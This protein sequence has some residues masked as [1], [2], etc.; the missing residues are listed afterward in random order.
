M[1]GLDG[2][3]ALVTGA[4]AGVGEAVARRLAEEGVRVVLADR[5]GDA[6]QAVA[7]T[8]PHDAVGVACDVASPDDVTA[9]VEAAA[10]LTGTI[11]I[12]V[13]IAGNSRPAMLKNLDEETFASVVDVHLG[14]TYRTVRT[15]LQYLPDDGTGRI[16]TTT[17]A[18]GQSG[19]IG[20]ANYAAAKAGI[21]GF[22][23]SCA[24][25]LARKSITANA[26]APLAATAMT[27]KVRTDEK[28]AKLTLARI[29][30]GRFAE[31]AEVAGTFAFLASDDAAYMTGQVLAVDG[32]TVI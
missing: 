26:V 32:G 25:E 11:N 17:S 19:T 14:G 7:A 28:L 24:K 1:R 3:I 4:G 15:A 23:K 31:P 27:E 5:D 8:L 10:A 16:I 18:A 12:V 6:A 21:I 20:Q 2:R 9:A 13:C 22:T 29:P 30:L